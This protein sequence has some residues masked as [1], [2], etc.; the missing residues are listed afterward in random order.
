MANRNESDSFTDS[1]VILAQAQVVPVENKVDKNERDTKNFLNL[2]T[3]ACIF[4]KEISEYENDGNCVICIEKLEDRKVQVRKIFKCGHIFHE[5]C[6]SNW[7]KRN[8]R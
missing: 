3:H 6:L 4:R 2:N 7:V 1:E 8:L 5:K